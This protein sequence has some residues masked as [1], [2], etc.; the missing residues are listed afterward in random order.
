MDSNTEKNV[1]PIKALSENVGN[2]TVSIHYDQRLY[3]QDIRGSIAHANMLANQGIIAVS[4]KDDIL[5]G[6]RGN[7]VR[8]RIRIF[9][10][11]RRI[12]RY[13]YEYRT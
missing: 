7:K 5:L 12:R 8:N 11:E 10:V 1:P 3:R 13:T 9:P 2:F 4:E 6:F